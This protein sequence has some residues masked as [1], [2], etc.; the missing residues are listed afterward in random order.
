MGE[1]I[2]EKIGWSGGWCGGFIWVAISSVIFLYR[3]RWG[4]GLSGLALVA[5]AGASIFLAAPWRHPTTPYWRLMLP[6]FVLLLGS[7]G[8]GVW[9]YGGA[10]EIGLDWW[11]LF[12]IL[13][14]LLPFVNAGKIRWQDNHNAPQKE[15][16]E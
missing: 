13:P 11:S 8:W 14:L 5:A 12:W 7:A 3:G 15:R 16:K 9:A 4:E 6:P 10:E 1:R 2:G